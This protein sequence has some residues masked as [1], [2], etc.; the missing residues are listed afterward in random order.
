MTSAYRAGA[1]L[2][3]AL[4]ARAQG[5]GVL[6]WRCA[7]SKGQGATDV[8][9]VSQWTGVVALNVKRGGWAPPGERSAMVRLTR[10]GVLP[11][12]VYATVRRGLPTLW[13]FL[14]CEGL[15]LNV[16]QA[17]ETPPWTKDWLAR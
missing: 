5:D 12:L 3:R 7:G 6:A 14:E 11:V 10:H 9:V 4:V 16:R 8:L 17:T 15:E 13:R 1:D 2:E